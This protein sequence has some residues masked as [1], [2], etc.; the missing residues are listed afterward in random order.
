MP[1]FE[2]P[3][4]RIE[5]K[6]LT[7]NTLSTLLQNAASQNFYK[8]AG[9]YN[10]FEFYAMDIS[11][12]YAVAP[13]FIPVLD[14]RQFTD[15]SAIAII[16]APAIN[17]SRLFKFKSDD[18]IDTGDWVEGNV[19]F[20]NM[21]FGCGDAT[22]F[23]NNN[24]RYSNASVTV[25][26]ANKAGPFVNNTTIKQDFVRHLAKS[27]TGGYGLSEI[28]T[29]EQELFDGV[30]N[31][32]VNFNAS[33]N[34]ILS[35]SILAGSTTPNV[36]GLLSG[37][38]LSAAN[39]VHLSCQNLVANL[40][41]LNVSSVNGTTQNGDAASWER[42]RRFLEDL[43]NQ[44]LAD[45]SD[46]NFYVMFR[47]KDVLAVKLTYAPYGSLNGLDNNTDSFKSAPGYNPVYSRSY[48]VY[49]V[50]DDPNPYVVTPNPRPWV[51]S[52]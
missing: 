50:M 32:D 47:D 38:S 34:N 36:Y 27:I 26:L 17:F 23:N 40:L 41:A 15:V 8:T 18:I 35:E 45:I 30:A 13:S 10:V 52:S 12:T 16:H 14:S 39:P 25:G 1:T 20:N 31:M 2:T 28:F 21:Y 11:Q 6:V 24:V 43:S 42:G 51:T 46:N 22:V 33:M 3:G 49:I 29:N 19:S 44:T 5:P 4:L 37:T 9:D 48:K 7:D